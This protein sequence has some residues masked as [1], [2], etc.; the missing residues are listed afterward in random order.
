MSIADSPGQPDRL[1]ITGTLFRRRGSRVAFAEDAPRP[2]PEPT[3]RPAKV[4]RMLALA[5]HL[6]DAINRGLV[7][8]RA[9]IARKLGL[10]SAR[11]AGPVPRRYGHARR[12]PG[13]RGGQ[14]TNRSLSSLLLNALCSSLPGRARRER[15]RGALGPAAPS[16]RS[17]GALSTRHGVGES[18]GRRGSKTRSETAK[19]PEISLW[20]LR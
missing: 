10:T 9:G 12:S 15:R 8:D 3:R 14:L 13:S 11:G 16:R 1:V 6:Q 17:L 19:A 18:A 2:E 7:A 5:H 20:G 4:A